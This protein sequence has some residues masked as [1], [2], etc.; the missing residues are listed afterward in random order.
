MKNIYITFFSLCLCLSL[1]SCKK[2][3]G[4][5]SGNKPIAKLPGEIRADRALSSDSVYTFETSVLVTNN[6]VLTIAP[7][8]VIKSRNTAGGE[9]RSDFFII[10][11]G[12]KIIAEGT[13][14][15]PIVFTS[16]SPAS[17]RQHGD[18]GGLYIAGNAPVSAYDENTGMP[19]LTIAPRGANVPPGGG[20][21]PADNSGVLKYVRIEFAGISSVDSYG[22]TCVGVGSGTVIENVQV[23]YTQTSGF[24]FFGGTVNA[25]NLI[26]FNTRGAGFLY[27]NGYNGNQ[28]FLLSYKHPYFAAPGSFIYTCDGIL[29]LNDIVNNP[30]ERNTRPVISNLTVIGPY[31]NPGYNDMQPWNA[32]INMNYN[33]NIALRNSILMGMPKGGLKFSDDMAAMHLL[34]GSTEFSYN[35]A[36]SN[37]FTDAY[38]V[39]MSYVYSVDTTAVIEYAESHNNTRHQS[40]DDIALADPFNFQ[41]PNTLPRAGSA[42]LTGANF[43]GS[44]FDKVFFNKVNYR[45]AFGTINWMDG[46][47]NFYPVTTNYGF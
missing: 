17:Q 34:D 6:A 43:S 35:M 14:E 44:D 18:W 2:N 19:S 39:D 22:L 21:D 32:A 4:E 1:F 45:G 40:P 25:R 46:W 38:T 41:L 13:K 24:G 37:N 9:G 30:I 3:D 28:Q 42:A 31:N 10:D 15:Q 29:V 11:R 8:T 7:G 20:E 33:S 26:A 47:T 12:A 36:H 5:L 16:G 23:S 27:T